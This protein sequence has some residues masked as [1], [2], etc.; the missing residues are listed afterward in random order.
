MLEVVSVVE[1]LVGVSVMDLRQMM[2]SPKISQAT[3]DQGTHTP[4]EGSSEAQVPP[5]HPQEIQ[6][7]QS[8]QANEARRI[9]RLDGQVTKIIERPYAGGPVCEVWEGQWVKQNGEGRRGGVEKV[10]LS[11]TTSIPLTGHSLGRLENTSN[12][13]I[14]EGARG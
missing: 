6:D 5:L 7:I 11:L 8:V 13:V 12:K 14:Y 9:E 2:W 4:G 10:S 1:I 3:G